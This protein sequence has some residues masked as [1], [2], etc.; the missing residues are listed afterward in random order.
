MT[1][2]EG[3]HQ[4]EH[5]NR[6]IRV[7][8]MPNIRTNL[9]PRPISFTPTIRASRLPALRTLLTSESDAKLTLGPNKKTPRRA[10]FTVRE[11]QSHQICPRPAS[12]ASRLSRLGMAPWPPEKYVLQVASAQSW[13]ERKHGRGP[14]NFGPV[15]L[16]TLKEK[17]T[18]VAVFLPSW[19]ASAS[20]FGL[21]AMCSEFLWVMTTAT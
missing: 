16:G 10:H 1:G 3:G 11:A 15:K 21:I 8:S 7:S 13:R 17:W 5:E 20:P 4:Q 19:V 6:G 9:S 14:L 12:L 2:F 18:L